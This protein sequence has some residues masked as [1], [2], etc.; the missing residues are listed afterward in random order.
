MKRMG[1]ISHVKSG[2][3]CTYTMTVFIASD[4]KHVQ[5]GKYVCSWQSGLVFPA[6]EVW[7]GDFLETISLGFFSW[8]VCLQ[9]QKVAEWHAVT[10]LVN[11]QSTTVQFMTVW[12]T[13]NYIDNKQWEAKAISFVA[14]TASFRKE[15]SSTLACFCEKLV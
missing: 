7:K 15:Y 12:I 6:G 9:E 11:D 14:E 13:R 4:F 1:N 10:C 8:N 5:E 2:Q 3:D